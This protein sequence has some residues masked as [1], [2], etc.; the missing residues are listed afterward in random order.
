[1]DNMAAM[2][3]SILPVPISKAKPV[4][5]KT[6]AKKPAIVKTKAIEKLFPLEEE[7]A[8]FLTTNVTEENLETNSNRAGN[9]R[10]L[11]GSITTPR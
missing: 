8:E 2:R 1:M 5:S 6:V 4:K 11:S 10:N 7:F 9:S 3:K